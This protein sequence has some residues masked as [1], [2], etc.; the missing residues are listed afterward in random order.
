MCNVLFSGKSYNFDEILKST[1]SILEGSETK[2]TYTFYIYDKSEL[3]N[4]VS[5]KMIDYLNDIVE[6]F[7]YKNKVVKLDLAHLL[8][9][10]DKF[11]TD[12]LICDE[13]Y[14]NE[15]LESQEIINECKVLK[16]IYDGGIYC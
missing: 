10:L 15:N 4:R 1:L 11:K 3:K 8:Q 5:D 6:G 13:N 14:K 2:E 16:E 12:S 7:N 9:N